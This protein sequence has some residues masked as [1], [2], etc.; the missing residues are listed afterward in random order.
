VSSRFGPLA[1]YLGQTCTTFQ[2][3]KDDP[4]RLQTISYKYTVRPENDEQPKFRWEYTKEFAERYCR[5]HL[6]GPIVFP[7][8]KGELS[9]NDVHLP[10]GYVTVEEIVRFC[11][12]DLEARPL[13]EDWHS[14]LEESY[15]LF[16]TKFAPRGPAAT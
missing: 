12:V 10:T 5:H 15:R 8:G 14:H 11:I 7:F 1:L 4:S 2:D 16:K 13:S 9:L 6:Q 3:A